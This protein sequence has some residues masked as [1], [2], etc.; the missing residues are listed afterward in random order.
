MITK[1][2]AG[3]LR[4]LLTNQSF[5]CVRKFLRTV[6]L[7]KKKKIFASF[8]SSALLLSLEFQCHIRATG[9]QAF[10]SSPSF[11]F[12]H[13]DSKFPDRYE[14]ELLSELDSRAEIP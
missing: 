10:F 9:L 13:S 6:L 5:L 14:R 12:A 7:K 2:P 11:H 8:I 4:N 1:Y 3:K